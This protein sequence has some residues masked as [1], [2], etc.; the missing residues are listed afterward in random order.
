MVVQAVSA[1]QWKP[2]SELGDLYPS[3]AIAVSNLVPDVS[4]KDTHA[5]GDPNG[6]LGITFTPD[7]PNTPITLALSCDKA[8]RLFEPVVLEVTV[9]KAGEEY[10]ITPLIPFNQ[11]RLASL[12][13]PT[14]I[15]VTYNLTIDGQ[16]QPPR[17]ERLRVR[18]IND[19]PFAVVDKD[20]NETSTDFM[21]AAYVNEEHPQIQNILQDALQKG[22]VDSFV[23]YQDGK[24]GVYE[25]VSAIWRV[26]QERGIR[27]STI[28]TVV[29]TAAGVLSQ[30][31]R[32]LEE[33]I[34]YTQANCVDGS[35]L[36]ASVLRKIGIRPVLVVV[37]GHMF[38]GFDLDEEGDEQSYLETTRLGVDARG[39]EVRNNR[40]Y[41]SLL[42]SQVDTE[43]QVALKSFVAALVS[44]NR[45]FEENANNIQ[46]GKEGYTLVDIEAAREAGIMP[47]MYV[48]PAGSDR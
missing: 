9:P 46:S 32:L 6:F 15:Y 39:V 29:P 28:P 31:V 27:Y 22:Y 5:L 35:V 10:L 44:G 3:F 38:I 40:L 17:T 34:R 26:L 23:G 43:A 30:H 21:F 12:R 18:S 19:C 37:P 4:G 13:Q 33:S 20:G 1:Q 7:H 48:S 25:Q 14:T 41:R 36:L 42:G 2:Y 11:T 47:I 45:T 24:Q 16:V 8:L